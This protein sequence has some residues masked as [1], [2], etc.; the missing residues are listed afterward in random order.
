MTMELGVGTAQ[1]SRIWPVS[2]YDGLTGFA[3]VEIVVD[4]PAEPPHWWQ[5]DSVK[6]TFQESEA[7]TRL[8]HHIVQELHFQ[9][10][11]TGLKILVGRTA[12]PSA[13]CDCA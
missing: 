12:Q 4:K 5:L 1:L 11:L 7:P 6:L 9:L 10:Q 8:R 13:G 3:T 2:Y